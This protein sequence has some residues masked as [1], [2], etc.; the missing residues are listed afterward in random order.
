[1]L[2]CCLTGSEEIDAETARLFNI[3]FFENCFIFL[4]MP[5]PKNT[6]KLLPAKTSEFGAIA[7]NAPGQR[8]GIFT[9]CPILKRLGSNPG[10]AAISLSSLT[11]YFFEIP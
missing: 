1:M 2:S 6:H 7:D 10:L 11:P 8:T 4:A 5:A 9:V 3:F